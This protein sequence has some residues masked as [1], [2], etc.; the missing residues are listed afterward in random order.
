M[1]GREFV[2][3]CNARGYAPVQPE[4]LARIIDAADLHRYDRAAPAAEWCRHEAVDLM[5]A[6]SATRVM[7]RQTPVA[8][9]RLLEAG[10]AWT[11][12]TA[13]LSGT[14]IPGEVVR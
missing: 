6:L 4:A 13:D 7:P 11:A 10:K 8:A 3:S 14:A 5:T 9:E 12:V 1:T 2:A